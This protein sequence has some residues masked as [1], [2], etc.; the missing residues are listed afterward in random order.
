MNNSNDMYIRSVGRALNILKS[1]EYKNC[2]T[3]SEIAKDCDLSKVTTLR[4]LSTLTEE[5]FLAKEDNKYM[6]GILFLRLG[7]IAVKDNDFI[8]VSR[9]KMIELSEITNETVSLNAII[10]DKRV[11]LFKVE[12]NESLRQ[13]I[14]VGKGEYMHKGGTGKLLL[15]FTT[16]DV[17][18]RIIENIIDEDEEFIEKLKIDLI[19]IKMEGFASTKDERILG[20][21]SISAP[22]FR[23]DGILRGSIAI[24][25][26]SV[27]IN[28]DTE[29]RYKN[30][31]I[32]K[33]KEI[34]VLL[35]YTGYNL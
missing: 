34:S 6:L 10:D 9:T 33:A 17:R 18:N 29:K 27:R 23:E 25:S 7:Y 22:I 19:K 20:S 32:E 16:E 15:A 12:G 4:M 26:A 31:V 3:L 1:F 13:F 28:N 24:S 21:A 2:K 30:L 8:S 5:E 35:G 11:C 14:E